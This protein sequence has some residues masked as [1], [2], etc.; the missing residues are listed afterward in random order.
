MDILYITPEPPSEYSGGGIAVKQSILS[1]YKFA[2]IHYIGPESKDFNIRKYTDKI[3]YLYQ[4]NSYIKK[5]KNLL[6]GVT[7]SY[8]ESWK[9]KKQNIK[10]NDYDYVFLE[11]SKFN[12]VVKEVKKHKINIILRLH[13]VEYMY[14]KNILKNKKSFYNIINLIFTKYKE[15]YIIRNSDYIIMLTKKD[16]KDLKKIYGY[17]I[18]NN[19]VFIC[20]IS[21]ERPYKINK[22]NKKSDKMDL[23]ITGSLWYEPNVFGIKWFLKEVW[24]ELNKDKY[25]LFLAGSRPSYGLKKVVNKYNNV[26]LVA[27]PNSMKPFFERADLYI[28]PIF[29]GSGMKVKIAEALSFGLPIVGTSHSFIGYDKRKNEN[30]FI[31]NSQ[32]EFIEK[33]KYYNNLNLTKKEKIKKNIKK[34]FDNNYSIAS[35]QRLYKMFFEKFDL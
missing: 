19:K 4:N 2:N 18:L 6:K 23:L 27:N 25:E 17:N 20:P 33:I 15:R 9:K 28:S 26:N 21:I 8:Y 1:L 32:S 29:E 5:M 31:A 11:F 34:K 22:N 24:G 30:L 14:R 35:S 3:D 7:S 13:N 10:W 12:F 16:K